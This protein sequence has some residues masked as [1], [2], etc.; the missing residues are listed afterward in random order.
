[1]PAGDRPAQLLDE[2]LWL[3]W[4]L[5]AQHRIDRP[6]H[7][8]VAH[9]HSMATDARSRRATA[10]RKA[11]VNLEAEPTAAGPSSATRAVNAGRTSRIK[12]LI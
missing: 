10:S 5:A 9:A 3:G 1:M 2:D 6:S 7:D 4:H 8:V 12:D 11:A